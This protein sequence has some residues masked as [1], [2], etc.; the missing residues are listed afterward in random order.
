MLESN[1]PD[2]KKN[3]FPSSFI[4]LDNSFLLFITYLS[5]TFL[6]ETVLLL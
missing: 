2:F 3:V 4:H 5:L 1:K 6:T